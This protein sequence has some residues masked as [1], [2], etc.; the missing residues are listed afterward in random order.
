MGTPTPARPLILPA[1]RTSAALYRRHFGL[2]AAAWLLGELPLALS[3]TFGGDNPM[4]QAVVG[5]LA[6]VFLL[7]PQVATVRFVAGAQAGTPASGLGG[8]FRGTFGRWGALAAAYLTFGNQV[9]VGM[10]LGL[11]PGLV[12]AVQGRFLTQVVALRPGELAFR[13]SR[14]AVRGRFFSLSLVTLLVFVSTGW[15]DALPWALDHAGLPVG[16]VRDALSV[17]ILAGG[18]TMLGAFACVFDTVLYL[19]LTQRSA[20]AGSGRASAVG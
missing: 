11:L 6:S 18:G 1:L 10:I 16:H 2:L 12:W 7:L 3:D 14:E 5:T 9:A 15:T 17:G 13:G 19:G 20:A 4:R 8:F